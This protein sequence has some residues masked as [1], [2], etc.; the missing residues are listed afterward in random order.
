MNPFV[1]L[2]WLQ[3]HLDDA[4]LRIVD[5]RSK[6]HG[7]RGLVFPSGAEQY[8]SGHIPGAVHLDYAVNLAD[9]ATPYAARVAPPELFAK[10]VGENGIGDATTVVAYDDGTTP[11]AAR[12]V[13]MFRLYGHDDVHILAGGLPAWVA[14]GLPLTA[15]VPA[16]P[17]QT[18]TPK[19]RPHLRASREEVLAVAEGRDGAQLLETQRDGTYKLRDRDI[20]GAVRLSASRLLQ[21]E[22]GGRIAPPAELERLIGEV[23]VDR[24]KRTIVTCGSGVGASG[25]HVALTEAGFTDLAV[26]DGSWMEWSHDNLPTVPKTSG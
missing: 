13:W 5:A 22:N 20:A 19:P 12:M 17:P 6:S 9:P 4:N 10:V 26:Y 1:E 18:F 25:A 11:Y 14:A 3:A 8:A 24:N 16:F 21:D 23:A 2:S 15:D 7:A